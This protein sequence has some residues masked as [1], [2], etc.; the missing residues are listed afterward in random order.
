MTVKCQQNTHGKAQLV[1]VKNS[2]LFHKR[3]GNVLPHS[4]LTG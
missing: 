1:E 3:G 4:N 2:K